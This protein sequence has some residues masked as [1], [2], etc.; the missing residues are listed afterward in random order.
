[1][2]YSK[3]LGGREHDE[4]LVKAGF[5]QETIA[6]IECPSESS[7]TA[8]IENEI[9]KLLSKG[10]SA[11]DIAVLSLRGKSADGVATQNKIGSY[12]VVRA[13]SPNIDENIVADTFLRFKGLERPAIIVTD[14]RLVQDR[15]DVR[16]HIALSRALDVVRIVTIKDVYANL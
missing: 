4:V 14:L 10:F 1:M 2:E 9:N 15:F 5:D 8:K 12:P 13:D 16:I 6:R 7:I 11:R 3:S